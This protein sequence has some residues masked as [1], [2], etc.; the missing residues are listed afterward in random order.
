MFLGRSPSFARRLAELV[1]ARKT[2]LVLGLDPVPD[3]L[4][5]N[6]RAVSAASDLAARAAQS[7]SVSCRLLIEAAGE[8]CVAIKP[9]LACFERLGSDG[10]QALQEVVG[11]ARQAGL[12]VIAD[13]K[14]GDVPH[15]A[16]A[17]SQSLFDGVD[18]PWGHV[19]GLGADAVTVNPLLGRDSIE[20]YLEASDAGGKGVFLLVRTSNAGAADIQDLA[21]GSGPLHEE[22]ARLTA[23]VGERL[24]DENGLSGV[25]AVVGATAPKRLA[26]LRELMPNTIFLVPGVGAQGGE[27]ESLAPAL[28]AH[29]A[30]ML[31]TVSRGIA[32]AH[33][34]RG[35]SPLAAARQA[36]KELS[37]AA[38]RLGRA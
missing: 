4:L 33:Q 19:P 1:E 34:T 36:A 22:L 28:A 29:P 38:W 35:G 7:T 24:I 16:E 15:S 25:G 11:Y 32:Q 23:K 27:M 30:S 8:F 26:R 37:E 2:R 21:C 12:L 9:Q 17:Y 18:T 31:V 14:R 6:D 13:G 3:Q 5:A 20:P 10:R